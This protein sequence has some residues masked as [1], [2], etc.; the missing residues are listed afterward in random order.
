MPSKFHLK[1]Q[2]NLQTELARWRINSY[3]AI[4]DFGGKKE[5][6]LQ[7]IRDKF[8]TIKR[9]F[10]DLQ[11]NLGKQSETIHVTL[12]TDAL[13]KLEK[14]MRAETQLCETEMAQVDSKY[15]I[16]KAEKTTMK[17][18][19]NSMEAF[20]SK[21]D[22]KLQNDYDEM[23]AAVFSLTET[24]A[25]STSMDGRLLKEID[26][27]KE[28]FTKMESQFRNI[29]SFTTAEIDEVK[30]GMRLLGDD[31]LYFAEK[32]GIS[33]QISYSDSSIPSPPSPQNDIDNNLAS[34]FQN[35]SENAAI[36]DDN[37]IF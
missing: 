9:Y 4:Q 36:I 30:N 13:S 26:T 11:A 8:K 18:K 31:I 12:S 29:K 33:Q 25:L 32:I 23:R 14:T 37:E 34:P 16:L 21:Q 24:A 22:E 2:K 28:H 3:K 10:D 6:E 35:N 15:E 7:T 1:T 19:F 27:L 5:E 20:I 17:E